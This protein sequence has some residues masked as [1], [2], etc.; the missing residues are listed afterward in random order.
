[1]KTLFDFEDKPIFD[2]HPQTSVRDTS[3]ESYHKLI[4][5]DKLGPCQKKVLNFIRTHPCVSDREIAEAMAMKINQVTGRRNEL[6]K[7]D[8]IQAKKKKFDLT[9]KRLVIAWEIK[10]CPQ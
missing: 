10:P 8:L 9:T 1:M 3:I 7:A 5:E 2:E 6:M 4:T